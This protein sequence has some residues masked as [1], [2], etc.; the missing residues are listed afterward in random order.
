MPERRRTR[1]GIAGIFGIAAAI[2]VAAIGV[3]YG[4]FGGGRSGPRP[5][6]AA[7]SEKVDQASCFALVIDGLRNG[8]QKMLP[9]LQQKLAA[10]D[11]ALPMSDSETADY[12]DAVSALRGGFP[13][14]AGPSRAVAVGLACQIL[15]R[16]AVEPC[17]ARWVETLRPVHDLLS[18][19][20][21]GHISDPRVAALEAMGRFWAWLP[22]RSLTPSEEKELSDWKESIF[23]PVVRCLASPD[24]TTRVAA[25]AC[26]GRLPLDDHAL[27][28]LPYIEDPTSVDVR[29]QALVSFSRRSTILTDDLLLKRLHDTDVSIRETAALILKTRG[30]TQEQVSMGALI[31]SPKPD[32]RISII[33]MLKNRTDIDPVVWL[34]QLSH[35]PVEMVRINAIEAL[36]GHKTAVVKRRLSEMAQSDT[37]E[38]VRKA[39]SKFVPAVQE[40]TASL[41]PLPGSP[42]LNPKAN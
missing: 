7:T 15:D 23:S 41:P 12:V 11:K 27:A 16:F 4:V 10:A 24:A 19:S 1:W 17:S 28:A 39:A 25:V 42:S 38:A 33:P 5:G 9:V 20:L 29:K 14:F 18:A 13:Q 32:Q 8:D 35:D 22:G 37:S 3:K 40:T 34:V 31:F 2:A 21:S 36:A 6:D 30:F 26:L